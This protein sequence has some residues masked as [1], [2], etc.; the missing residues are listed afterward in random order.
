VSFSIVITALVTYTRNTHKLASTTM[1]C[2]VV[3]VE[4]VDCCEQYDYITRTL[5]SSGMGLSLVTMSR[6]SMFEHSWIFCNSRW[7][8]IP[9]RS[10]K[11]PS[12]AIQRKCV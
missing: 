6:T 5:G 4:I 7:E 10:E 8:E 12:N 2:V 11:T 1:T 3:I 9:T